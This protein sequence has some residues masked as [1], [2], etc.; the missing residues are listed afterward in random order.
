MFRTILLASAMLVAA[1]A[2]AL[3]Q[4][5]AFAWDGFY[6]GVNAGY[7]GDQFAYPVTGDLSSGGI[8]VALDAKATLTSSG[9]LGGGQVGYNFHVS[10]DWVA[11]IEADIDAT[12]IKGELGL[13]G[14]L[15]GFIAG[16]AQIRAGSQI[17]YLGT[18]RARLGYVTDRDLLVY[19]T[20]GLAFGEVKSRYNLAV[21]SGGS[22][23]FSAAGSQ[24]D[25][26]TGWTAGVGAEYPISDRMTLKAE[27]LYADLGEH[28]L[29]STPFAL[30]G[31]TGSIGVKVEST[32]HIVRVGLNYALD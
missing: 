24:S 3:A 5:P 9:F 23:L 30:L 28:T 12:G 8:A 29:I 2:P 26:D 22:T 31:A 6:A 1:S 13:G 20:A 7:G 19:G 21:A 27:Y 16:A 15:S 18:V 25:T 4:P 32:A 17:D 11:G 10:D 14:A